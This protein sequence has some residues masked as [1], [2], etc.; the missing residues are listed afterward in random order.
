[1][2]PVESIITDHP[3]PAVLVAAGLGLLIGMII[4]RS[5]D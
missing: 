1:M 4:C 3:I 2:E 5:R